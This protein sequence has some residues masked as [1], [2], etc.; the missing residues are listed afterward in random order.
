MK[1]L[2]KLVN[3]SHGYGKYVLKYQSLAQNR[4]DTVEF[5]KI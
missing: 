2:V 1:S 3:S 4:Y 5:L